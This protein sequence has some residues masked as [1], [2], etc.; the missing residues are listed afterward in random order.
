MSHYKDR[1]RVLRPEHKL[2]APSMAYLLGVTPGQILRWRHMGLLGNTVESLRDFM[3]TWMIWRGAEKGQPWHRVSPLVLDQA[4]AA[5]DPWGVE[6]EKNG[7]ASGSDT[8]PV[9]DLSA[10]ECSDTDTES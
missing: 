7:C 10:P 6:Q 9:S 8:L 1:V 2:S 4:L 5:G 3:A